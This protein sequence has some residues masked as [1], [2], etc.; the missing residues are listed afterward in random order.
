[1]EKRAA[2]KPSEER[3]MK[4]QEQQSNRSHQKSRCLR[5]RH[6]NRQFYVGAGM[7]CSLPEQLL[8]DFFLFGKGEREDRVGRRRGGVVSWQV[9]LLSVH[10]HHAYALWATQRVM[11]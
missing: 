9:G 10:A 1:M 7:L 8:G 2:K 3:Q 4:M 5:C 6:S 11:K